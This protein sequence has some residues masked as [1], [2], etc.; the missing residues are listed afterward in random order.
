MNSIVKP[1][2][3]ARFDII[4]A[5]DDVTRKKPDPLIYNMTA[6]RLGLPADRCVCVC[7]CVCVRACVRVRVCV[8]A[9]V[10]SR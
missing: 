8:R 6:A 3:L 1:E 4:L 10:F 2:R 5:G 7:V 9:G